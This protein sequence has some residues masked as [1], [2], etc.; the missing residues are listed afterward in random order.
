MKHLACTTVLST[1][2]AMAGP[3]EADEA[4]F[5]AMAMLAMGTGMPD[6][7]PPTVQDGNYVDIG[8]SG[9]TAFGD[10][11]SPGPGGCS[12]IQ[13]TLRQDRGEFVQASVKTYDFSRITGVR[14]LGPGDDLLEAP[15]REPD[16]PEVDTISLDGEAWQ[17]QRVIHVDPVRPGFTQHC[18]DGWQITLLGDEDKRAA[19]EAID[20][21]RAS[22]FAP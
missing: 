21:I 16:D 5:K 6:V 4:L 17:C 20:L 22:C 13:T 8:F 7:L 1:M 11:L 18:D 3:A 19:R 14:Y 12:V 9:V 2:L 15:S 10:V